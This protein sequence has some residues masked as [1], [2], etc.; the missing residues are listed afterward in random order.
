M[1]NRRKKDNQLYGK[2]KK[3]DEKYEHKEEKSGM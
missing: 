2:E 3:E 1:K